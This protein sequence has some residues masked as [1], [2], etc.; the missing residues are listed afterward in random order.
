VSKLEQVSFDIIHSIVN[1]ASVILK[2][3]KLI[4][5]ILYRAFFQLFFDTF[6]IQ[7]SQLYFL[8][9]IFFISR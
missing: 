3:I 1:I 8:H 4:D 2:L 5:I 9:Y 6:C 7:S